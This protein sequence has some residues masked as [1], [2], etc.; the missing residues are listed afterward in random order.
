MSS[1]LQKVSGTLTRLDLTD[2]WP[3]VWKGLQLSLS[4]HS[5][6]LL[7]LPIEDRR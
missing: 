1:G 7:L 3:V 5:L 4:S 6:S 2:Q